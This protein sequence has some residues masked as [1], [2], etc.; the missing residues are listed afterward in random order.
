MS[1]LSSG[2]ARLLE[3]LRNSKA[4]KPA[5]DIPKAAPGTRVP[6]LPAQARIWYFTRRFPESAEYNLF[7]TVTF[8][9]G[10]DR[11][12]LTASVRT[13]IER[14]DALR[15]RIVEVDGEPV[16]E[17]CGA[18]EP[19]VTWHDLRDLGEEEAQ[20][21]A[22]RII[23]EAAEQPLPTDRAPLF[24]VI[25]CDMPGDRSLLA[26]GSHHVIIDHWSVGQLVEE[27]T[28]LLAGLPLPP[29]HRVG[30]LDYAAHQARHLD[31]GR[32]AR[33][34]AY[35]KEQ[36]GGVLP[37]LDLP[38]DRPRP[39]TES[40]S[41]DMV[42][43]EAGAGLTGDVRR[44]AA[45]ENTSLFVVLLAAYQA[46]VFRL[47]GQSDIV[48]GSPLAGR[49]DEVSEKIVGCFVKPVALR[50]DLSTAP[51]FRTLV[52][53]AQRTVLE[54]QDHQMVPFERIVA[55]LGVARTPGV[56]PVFQ[57][58]FGVQAGISVAAE[59]SGTLAGVETKSAR[60]DLAVS[61]TDQGDH[62]RGIFEYSSDLFDHATVER[63]TR[64]YL[65]VLETLIG[66]PETSVGEVPLL[67]AAGRQHILDGLNTYEKPDIRY[68]TLA[69]PFEEQVLRTPD[70]IALVGEEGELT[71][72][73]LNARANRL[74]HHLRDRGVRPGDTVAVCMDRGFP[75]V[76]ALYAVAKAGAAY[77][78]MD[79]ELPDGRMEF[80]LAD[81][82]PRLVLV[83]ARGARQVPDGPRPVVRLDGDDRPWE[84]CPIGNPAIRTPPNAPAFLLYTSGS[85]GRPKAVAYPVDGALANIFW[86]QR[87]Y[88]FGPGD[89]NILK[90]SYGF[91]V[92]TWELFWP[93][94]YGA[95]LVVA[96]PGG[97]RDPDHLLELTE[98]YQVTT[99]FFVPTMMEVFLQVAPPG[100]CRSLRRVL[101]GGEEVKPR[102]RDA[103]HA[104]FDADLVN[105]CG[106][107]EAG[108]VVE[109]HI[110]REPGVPVLPLGRPCANFRVY[111]LGPD[112]EVLPVGVPGEMYIG[113]ETGLAHGYH[114]RPAMTA[115][116]F[117]PDPFGPEGGRMY[118]TGDLCRFREDGV[119]EHLGR[120]DRQ[121]KIRGLR[122]ELSEIESVLRDHPDVRACAALAPSGFD[123]RIAAFVVPEPGSDPSPRELERHA[124]HQL[125]THMVPAAV[126]TVDHIP[127]N[128]N[129][130]I[131]QAPLLERLEAV[132][133][134][135]AGGSAELVEP[136]GE[137][138]TRLAAVFRD[139]L[140]IEALSVTDG[141]FALGGHSLLVFKLIA[142]CAREL[143]TGPTVS[144]VF[145]AP[146]VRE[147]AARLESAGERADDELVPLVRPQG[148]P[149]VLLVHGAGGSVL[150][151]QPV[152][153]ALG[154]DFDVYGLQVVE[155]EPS[156][157]GES[158]QDIA[159][160]YV[161]AVDPVRGSRPFFL[162][163]WSVGG[164]VALE[165][166]RQWR[167]RGAEPVGVAL[168]DSWL[169]PA[170]IDDGAAAAQARAA[171]EAMD[172][173]AGEGDPAAE[174]TA[175]PEGASHI[176]AVL[177]RHRAAFLA[178]AP[179]PYAGEVRLLRAAERFPDPRVEFPAVLR[180]EDNGWRARI[181]GLVCQEIPGDHFTLVAEENSAHLAGV[182]HEILDEMLSFTEI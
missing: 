153:A 165:M 18:V 64:M 164:C 27:L 47:T 28:R 32:T 155:G 182:I 90:T 134:V 17:D 55:E 38:G 137:T 175:L 154:G 85:T 132:E 152:A 26:L 11:E 161:R 112:Q 181:P 16:Q 145:A 180:A 170:A 9:K 113:G 168:L 52:R 160:R 169:P 72:A 20:A 77:V 139:V 36:L 71:Y 104:H 73:E 158:I 96:R 103:F 89:A 92:S 63:F 78:P 81:T 110:P 167:A 65:H 66:A 84:R 111:V 76:I 102:L 173:L 144:D 41:G 70:G 146:S 151:F 125:P 143:G 133:T 51:D 109:G 174:P 37:V 23:E 118:R 60:T 94:Y 53:Q 50:A 120:I 58:I 178:Y 83:D 148:R 156:A 141:F 147:L 19:P 101:I 21:R 49:D 107:T 172:L 59:G 15:L 24:R 130:K 93:L 87:H 3:L 45:Q 131:D 33:E 149:M 68:R 43:F 13:L 35:W 69:E 62:L 2:Q 86:L 39:A 150:P 98:K 74:A 1:Q 12:L 176:P 128:V 140:G 57:T 105:C 10:L 54:A 46:F 97:H 100:S 116:R 79:P 14:H 129:G 4:G 142:A 121:V 127:Y 122:I 163:G 61:V 6:L 56:N 124:R 126:I 95:R 135:A 157:P 5:L 8:E 7:D 91:D 166:A 138:E 80:I 34:L 136:E 40:R 123:G 31:E 25:A 29:A 48:V 115:E 159:A 44:F 119:L 171:F 162:A 82:E 106:P 88:P 67:T 75:M 108:T 114:N 177:E 179:E 30:Y 22:N 117:L 42:A 99:L